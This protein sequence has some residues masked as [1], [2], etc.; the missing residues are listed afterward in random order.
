MYRSIVDQYA[1]HCTRSENVE[2]EIEMTET[3][4]NPPAKPTSS[5]SRASKGLKTFK[6]GKQFNLNTT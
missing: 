4:H 2:V 6:I 1:G 5:S 3:P